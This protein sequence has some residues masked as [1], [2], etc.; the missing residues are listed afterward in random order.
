M[1]QAK[2][3]LG[4]DYVVLAKQ[5]K[6]VQA[7]QIEVLEFFSYHCGRCFDVSRKMEAEARRWPNYAKLQRIQVMWGQPFKGLLRLLATIEK[8]G[9]VQTLHHRIFIAFLEQGLMLNDSNTALNWVKKQPDINFKKFVEHFNSAAV[10]KLSNYYAAKTEEY[11]VDAT[12]MVI[13]DGRYKVL[14]SMPDRMVQVTR[15][16]IAK[17]WKEA[18]RR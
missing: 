11:N 7:N 3:V 15:E 16:L 2:I 4:K 6:R 5:H 13:V 12:P 9:K 18:K 14:P 10:S 1:A 17:A 8:M